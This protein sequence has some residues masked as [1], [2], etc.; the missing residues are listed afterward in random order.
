MLDLGAGNAPYRELFAHTRLYD[1]RLVT[2]AA[3]RAQRAPTSSRSADALPLPSES[4]FDLVI[5]TQVL[6]HV[7][8]PA[9]VL[10][11]CSACSAPEGRS[12]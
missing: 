3:L 11:E 1:E 6:E 10:T 5:C 4:Q 7:P 12:R 9:A 2:V 8:E